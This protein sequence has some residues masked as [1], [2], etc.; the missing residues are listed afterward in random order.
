[1]GFTYNL[2]PLMSF[3]HQV[4]NQQ[5]HIS[6]THWTSWTHTAT[7]FH[8]TRKILSLYSLDMQVFSSEISQWNEQ[9]S[10]S[11]TPALGDLCIEGHISDAWSMKVARVMSRWDKPPQSWVLRV[12]WTWENKGKWGR[13][14]KTVIT[15]RLMWV[16]CLILLSNPKGVCFNLEMLS[17][18]TSL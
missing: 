6:W 10:S 12:I 3:I 2:W 1:M 15:T 13:K 7:C 17:L 5:W 9:M 11:S 4:W 14:G 18:F 16:T 8:S